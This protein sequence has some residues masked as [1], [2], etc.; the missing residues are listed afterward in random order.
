VRG[1]TVWGAKAV[2]QSGN[3]IQVGAAGRFMHNSNG[4]DYRNPRSTDKERNVRSR[5]AIPDGMVIRK[6]LMDYAVANNTG[7]GHVLHFFIV[8]SDSA[9]GFRHPMVGEESDKFGFGAEGQRL[10]I[11]P[12]VDLTRRGLSPE[13]LVIARTL[14]T[15]G[16][17]IGDNAGSASSL[18]AEQES[19]TNPV[20]N[21][22]LQADELRGITWADFYVIA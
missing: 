18:K 12:D 15:H 7:L 9:A 16:M 3:V 20:W 19:S 21:G 1:Q 14:Q 5:G 11:R 6:D 8:E 4:L 2:K 10:A 17:Y 13:G 22:R